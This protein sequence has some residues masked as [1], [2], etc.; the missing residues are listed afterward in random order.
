VFYRK[1]SGKAC[2]DFDEAIDWALCFGWI[3][4]AIRKI[5]DQKYARRFTPR[6]SGSVWSKSNIERAEALTKD[7]RM[8]EH[9]A[10]AFREKTNRSS[11]ARKVKSSVK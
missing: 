5:D 9:G 2:I 6:R 7:G 3:D 11:V 1:G 10:A 4:S 8:T